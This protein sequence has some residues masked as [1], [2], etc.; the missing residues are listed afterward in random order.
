VK[1]ELVGDDAKLCCLGSCTAVVSLYDGFADRATSKYSGG[2]KARDRQAWLPGPADRPGK[3]GI[4]CDTQAAQ[5]C[6]WV[7]FV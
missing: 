7:H 1:P 3:P 5:S 2:A 6:P 4:V